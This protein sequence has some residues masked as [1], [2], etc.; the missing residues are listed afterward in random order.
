M[1]KKYLFILLT[2]VFILIRPFYV[3]SENLDSKVIVPEVPAFKDASQQKAETIYKQTEGQA[4]QRGGVKF[5][6]DG[7][8]TPSKITDPKKKTESKLRGLLPKTGESQILMALLVGIFILLVYISI[9]IKKI[10]GGDGY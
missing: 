3:S 9:N 2:V 10:K 6:G 7:E 4:S 5:V 8:I 1:K